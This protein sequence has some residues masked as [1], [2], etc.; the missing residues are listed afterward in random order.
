[1]PKK[2]IDLL[3][4]TKCGNFFLS[5]NFILEEINA[6]KLC[7]VGKDFL[8]MQLTFDSSFT[9]LIKANVSRLYDTNRKMYNR[10]MDTISKNVQYYENMN[11]AKECSDLESTKP[12]VLS[13]VKK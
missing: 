9:P 4:L 11:T 2:R 5:A 12:L 13:R 8:L 1:M 6:P 7:S 10:I 3:N